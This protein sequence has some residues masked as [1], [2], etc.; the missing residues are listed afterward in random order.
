MRCAAAIA[1]II[2]PN[3]TSHPGKSER[4][5]DFGPVMRGF[6]GSFVEQTDATP[7]VNANQ[8]PVGLDILDSL[9]VLGAGCV[10]QPA[11]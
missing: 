6:D 4:R 9:A 3:R 8:I 7:P 1:V 11:K 2:H 10:W 5:E